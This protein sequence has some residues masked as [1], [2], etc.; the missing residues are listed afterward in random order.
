[1]TPFFR[2][3][4]LAVLAA[5]PLAAQQP[6]AAAQPA[7]ATCSVDFNQPKEFVTLY[8]ITRARVI[9]QPAGD[10]RAKLLKDIMKVLGNPKT[11]AVNPLGTAVFSGQMLV[12]WMM[13]PGMGATATRGQMNWG[14]PKDATVDLARTVDSLFTAVERAEPACISETKMWREAKPWQDRINGAFKALQATQTDS[15]EALAVS[16]MV[17]SRTSPYAERVLAAVAQSRNKQGEMFKHLEAALALTVGDTLYA[18]DRR[19]VLFSVGQVGLEYAETQPEPART[20]I[21][22]RSVAAMVALATESPTADA[23][24]Y[25]LSGLGM[26]ATSL[27]DSSLFVQC[28]ALVDASLDKFNDLATLQAAVCANRNGKTAD[29]A[30]MFQATI[31]KNPNSRDA[32]YNAAALLYELRKGHEMLPLVTHLMELDP[33]NPDNVS[34]FAYA[35]NVLHEQSKS[36]PVAPVAPK[37]TWID[38]VTKYMKLSDEM[39]HKVLMSE[40]TRFADKALLR[41][42]IENRSKTAKTYT[43]EVEFL[44]VTGAVLDKQSATVG[45]VAPTQLGT[46][47]LTTN[48]PK[49]V[50]WRYAPLK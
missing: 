41:G 37:E 7:A 6:A 12:L 26:A 13:Q 23:A 5:A 50:A 9:Q 15:A 2:I 38:S 45:P 24:P 42:D 33:S 48:K 3:S 34:L 17:L 40:F 27:K 22:R 8:N 43:L 30:R 16:S 10:D 4:L 25:A 49:V 36:A 44:D 19:A 46:F 18:E 29:A 14:E 28:F 1:M 47:S 39:P 11:S 21:L 20:D 32:L 31:A 35:Y